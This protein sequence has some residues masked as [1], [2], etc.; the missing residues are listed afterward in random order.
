[1]VAGLTQSTYEE[2]CRELNLDTLEERRKI[3]D[4]A[5]AYKMIQGNEK[6]NRNELFT[7]ID[8]S[9]TRQDADNLNLKKAPARLE[10]RKNFFT[11]RI[12]N[13]WNALPS[14]LKRSTNVAG[15]KSA[16]R[17]LL[18]SG[19]DGMPDESSQTIR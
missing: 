4:M 13:D 8:G 19:Q 6:L 3:Q 15:F 5:Q 7:H 10:I 12:I 2:K 17:N 1:M 14:Q 9:R 18:R 11:Q 16:Y